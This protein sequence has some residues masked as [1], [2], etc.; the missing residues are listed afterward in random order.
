ML[1]SQWA[2]VARNKLNLIATAKMHTMD[3]LE[4]G[5]TGES[6]FSSS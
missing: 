5:A 1:A 2:T 3:L 4:N 6:S